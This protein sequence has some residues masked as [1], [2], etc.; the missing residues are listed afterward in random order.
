MK[1]SVIEWF[2]HLPPDVAKKAIENKAK[3]S[4]KKIETETLASAISGSFGWFGSPEGPDYWESMFKGALDS[5]IGAKPRDL[6]ISD[7]DAYMIGY[8]ANETFKNENSS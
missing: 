6:Q 5:S 8:N 2:L 7:T 3:H 4:V 1:K